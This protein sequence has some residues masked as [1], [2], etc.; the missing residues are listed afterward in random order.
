MAGNSSGGTGMVSIGE[1]SL[2]A[3]RSYSSGERSWREPS[4]H[5]SAHSVKTQSG[6]GFP[7]PGP[8]FAIAISTPSLFLPATRIVSFLIP[9]SGS[10]DPVLSCIGTTDHGVKPGMYRCGDSDNEHSIAG[11]LTLWSLARRVYALQHIPSSNAPGLHVSEF[12]LLL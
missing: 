8:I 12:L 3:R 7:A 4:L 9:R 6:P 1:P 10:Q 11:S 5:N 2:E